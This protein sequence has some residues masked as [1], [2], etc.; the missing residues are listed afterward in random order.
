MRHN[1]PQNGQHRGNS[2]VPGPSEEGVERGGKQPRTTARLRCHNTTTTHVPRPFPPNTAPGQHNTVRVS[3]PTTHCM[4]PF[5][6]AHAPLPIT[7]QPTDCG[8]SSRWAG[9][10]HPPGPPPTS[11]SLP[12]CQFPNRHGSGIT[13]PSPARYPTLPLAL[14]WALGRSFVSLPPPPFP[15]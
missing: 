12:P 1:E 6:P 11:F 9:A 15:H 7:V 5:G 2:R 8:S 14:S 13:Q 10:R 3:A 4:A